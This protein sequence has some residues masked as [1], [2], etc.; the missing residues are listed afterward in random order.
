MKKL[1]L[2]LVALFA[3]IGAQAS[4]Q[5]IEKGFGTSGTSTVKFGATGKDDITAKAVYTLTPN[6]DNKLE[7]E[8]TFAD[9]NNSD[10]EGLGND[11]C[12]MFIEG[13][14]ETT[15]SYAD[16][17]YTG[18]TAG[19][20]TSG[21]FYSNCYFKRTCTNTGANYGEAGQLIFP[22]QF[23]APKDGIYFDLK[24]GEPTLTTNSYSFPYEIVVHPEGTDLT[25]A[26]YTV[27]LQC[28]P[29]ASSYTDY[30]TQSGTIVQEGLTPNTTY[31]IYTIAT[32]NLKGIEYKITNN[33]AVGATVRTLENADEVK[34][35]IEAEQTAATSSSVTMHYKFVPTG[36][37]PEGTTYR[38]WFDVEGFA[39]PEIYSTDAEG[40]ITVTGLDSEKTYNFWT[41]AYYTLP[42]AGEQQVTNFNY[43][44]NPKTTVGGEISG[45]VTDIAK[46]T[47]TLSLN[48]E[49]AEGKT[50]EK[51][52][53]SGLGEGKDITFT[54][55]DNL[56]ANLTGLTPGTTYT[57][58]FTL[59]YTDNSTAVATREFRT[60]DGVR[61]SITYTAF[62]GATNITSNSADLKFTVTLANPDNYPVEYWRLASAR[63]ANDTKL[64]GVE[65][66]KWPYND[67]LVWG[68]YRST[69][70]ADGSYEITIPLK[71]LP[72]G[73]TV[74]NWMKS[75]IKLPATDAYESGGYNNQTV[76]TLSL[77]APV[78][79][80]SDITY[81]SATLT[82]TNVPEGTTSV[83]VSGLGEGND[84]TVDLESKTAE[85]TGLTAETT[86]NLTLT[87]S[88]EDNKTTQSAVSFT[89]LTAPKEVTMEFIDV[90]VSDLSALFKLKVQ[91]IDN[92]TSKESIYMYLRKADETPEATADD[93]Y[94]IYG[95]AKGTPA[96]DPRTGIEN[97]IYFN[98]TELE[99]GTKYIATAVVKKDGY[100][101]IVQKEF[102][103]LDEANSTST[104]IVNGYFQD[105]AETTSDSGETLK[106]VYLAAVRYTFTYDTAAKVLYLTFDT[107]IRNNPTLPDL[108][109]KYLL[110]LSE[111]QEG[112]VADYDGYPIGN[113]AGFKDHYSFVI[114]N[115]CPNISY[116]VENNIPMTF[117]YYTDYRAGGQSHIDS[118]EY[119]GSNK[120]EDFG[121]PVDIQWIYYTYEEQHA[122]NK[123]RYDL[124]KGVPKT[125]LMATVLDAEG[126]YLPRRLV[127]F[128][129]DEEHKD[130]ADVSKEYFAE[131]PKWFVTA[132]S[133]ADATSKEAYFNVVAF[134]ELEDEAAPAGSPRRAVSADG[135]RLEA[136]KVFYYIESDTP[137]GIDDIEA[138]DANAPVRYFDLNGREI[139]EPQKGMFVIRLQGSKATKMIAE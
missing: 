70:G 23:T 52:V 136:K 92:A 112:D 41:K 31:N 77:D 68:D 120:S 133:L 123:N 28:D 71:N 111:T 64:D 75:E 65:Y 74:N 116:Y 7:V 79:E 129:M 30:T 36:E 90:N 124:Y 85:L 100:H 55:T 25:G 89:T 32:I 54:S 6:A 37:V 110:H 105:G 86:Y 8:L 69:N 98:Y 82:L 88:F 108:V 53:V 50:V 126:H 106:M 134:H 137:T 138:D 96:L 59:T 11:P 132:R 40:Y 58:T 16:G 17:K 39:N 33:D 83:V 45:T 19:A 13:I 95:E 34:F 21:N 114:N 81:N 76:T 128:E 97:P 107:R 72:A 4:T 84:I 48:C 118:V 101:G 38:L 56:T 42:D 5:T 22:F 9:L 78:A 44:F 135:K 60:V 35:S 3:A 2:C 57:L 15:L 63:A 122:Q 49:P 18:T 127:E 29:N 14:G 62:N 99:K 119:N 80:I 93:P 103:T 73:T 1:L 47:A 113:T 104:Y 139:S 46:T 130:Y 102:T 43:V 121:E 10:V 61:P 51:I 20:A 91:L 109:S 115:R 26:T 94:A 66:E 131:Q 117:T 125:Q 27:R 67:D 12:Y 87:A 24:L